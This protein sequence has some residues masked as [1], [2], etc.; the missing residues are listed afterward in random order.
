MAVAAAPAVIIPAGRHTDCGQAKL[1]DG[2]IVPAVVR[3]THVED[4][5]RRKIVFPGGFGF[6]FSEI[7]LPARSPAVVE[8]QHV[9]SAGDSVVG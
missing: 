5:S 7:F 2:G 6:K 1:V 3:W 8:N 9:S 4:E